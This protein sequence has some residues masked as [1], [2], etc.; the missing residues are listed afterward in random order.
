MT[1]FSLS[2]EAKNKKGEKIEMQ[3]VT[4]FL[5]QTTGLN[6]TSGS[7]LLTALGTGLGIAILVGGLICVGLVWR[8]LTMD[9]SNGEWKMEILKGFLFLVTPAIVTAMFYKLYGQALVPTF[10]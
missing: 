9:R 7:T 6:V 3:G 4:V 1:F 10:N 5:A 2:A 8:G